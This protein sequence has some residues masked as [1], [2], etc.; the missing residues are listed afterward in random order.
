MG[1][2]SAKGVV[3]IVHST[4][5]ETSSV[6]S[7][8]N[9][10]LRI[11][12]KLKKS[13]HFGSLHWSGNAPKDIILYDVPLAAT[14]QVGDTIVTGGMSAIFPQHI[15]LGIINEIIVPTNDNYYQLHISLFQDMTNLDYVYGVVIPKA[16]LIKEMII[17]NE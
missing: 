4:N 6:I 11:N 1:I 5:E 15:D 2:I 7:L 17:D 9:K 3:G 16:E 14:V 13:N 12:A 8:L 10:S